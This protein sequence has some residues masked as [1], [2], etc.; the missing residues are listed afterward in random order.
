MIILLR[1]NCGSTSLLFRLVPWIL[2]LNNKKNRSAVLTW[3]PMLANVACIR[4]ISYFKRAQIFFSRAQVFISRA[5]FLFRDNFFILRATV[6][7]LRAEICSQ[8]FFSFS[9]H[10]KD[11]S[12]CICNHEACSVT[13]FCS[14]VAYCRLGVAVLLGVSTEPVGGPASITSSPCWGLSSNRRGT[15]ESARLKQVISGRNQIKTCGEVADR[16]ELNRFPS[17][18]PYFSK[19]EGKKVSGPGVTKNQKGSR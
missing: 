7:N 14:L 4:F 8:T 12:T 5:L 9:S 11:K 18:R 2:L 1:F 6:F 10:N 15:S 17:A 3:S 13:H 16:I 19:R